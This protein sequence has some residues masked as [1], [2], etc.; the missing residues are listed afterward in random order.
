V[1]A[2]AILVALMQGLVGSLLDALWRAPDAVV[3]ALLMALPAWGLRCWLRVAFDHRSSAA[4]VVTRLLVGVVGLGTGVALAPV[5]WMVLLRSWESMV[6]AGLTLSLVM[7][8]PALPS[9]RGRSPTLAWLGPL[10]LVLLLAMLS[11]LVLLPGGFLRA[12]AGDVLVVVDLMGESRREIVRWTPLGLPPREEGFRAERL[13]LLRADGLPMGG[14]WMYGR[15]VALSGEA[16]HLRTRDGRGVWLVRFDAALNDAPQGDGR[17][18][19]YPPQRAAVEPLAGAALPLWWWQR[20][21]AWLE[22]LG[23]YRT[24]VT[25]PLLPLLDAQGLPLVTAHR[26]VIREDGTLGGP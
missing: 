1:R 8:S 24:A 4:T 21:P 22:V 23:L 2:R 13:R 9:V 26:L 20:Q 6:A 19:L 10:A 25:S 16:F 14:A 12:R 3:A 18:R 11:T 15:A 17:A 7:L 5:G